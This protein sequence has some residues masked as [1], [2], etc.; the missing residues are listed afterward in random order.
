MAEPRTR[1]IIRS[2]RREITPSFTLN[3]IGKYA[4]EKAVK[5]E[6]GSSLEVTT[7]VL[8]CPLTLEAVLNHVGAKLFVE[9]SKEPLVW[10]AIE[11]LSPRAKLE[12]IG[13]RCGFRPDF[14][15]A[16]FQH[17]GPMFRF[18]DRL[19]HGKTEILTARDIPFEN[20]D[21]SPM[22]DRVPALQAD[23]EHACNVETAERWRESVRQMTQQL[24]DAAGCLSPVT[25]G[26]TA[27]W[28]AD[29][30]ADE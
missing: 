18:R 10:L 23:W 22:L 17:F 6:E 8:M 3:Q 1:K 13:E 21:V 7:A 14:G 15:S 16:P 4:L 27:D 20:P 30:V 11:R 5:T 25:F 26:Y 2:A 24:C 12:A 28:S 9:D 29:L 19:A